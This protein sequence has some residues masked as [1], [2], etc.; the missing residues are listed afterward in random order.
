[1]V[2]FTLVFN[3]VDTVLGGAKSNPLQLPGQL[4]PFLVGTFS[5]ITICYRLFQEK[6]GVTQNGETV[7]GIERQDSTAERLQRNYSIERQQPTGSWPI[8]Y[9]VAY[10]PWLGLVEHAK[11][12]MPISAT[13]RE[14]TGLSDVL[15]KSG[16]E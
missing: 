1:M 2:E 10:L 11:P 5:F 12:D 3:H 7:A 8:R 6:V 14:G 9:L 13:I 15:I 16:E 4:L